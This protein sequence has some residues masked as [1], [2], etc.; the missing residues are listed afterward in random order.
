MVIS[1]L[2]KVTKRT[3]RP[4]LLPA[5]KKHLMGPIVKPA[6]ENTEANGWVYFFLIK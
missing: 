2:R 3:T 4:V 5:D 1:R 6:E